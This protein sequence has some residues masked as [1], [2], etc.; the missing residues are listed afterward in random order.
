MG[1][2]SNSFKNYIISKNFL[3]FY[4]YKISESNSKCKF[5]KKIYKKISQTKRAIIPNNNSSYNNIKKR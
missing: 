4:F 3:F 5:K 1:I 2:K